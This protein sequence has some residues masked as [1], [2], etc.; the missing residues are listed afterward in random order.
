MA[1]Y[2]KGYEVTMVPKETKG[3][4]YALEIDTPYP[5]KNLSLFVLMMNPSVADSRNMDPTVTTIIKNLGKNYSRII[6][7]NTTPVIETS[8]DNLKNHQSEIN[9]Q[10]MVNAKTV[11]RM[12]KEAKHFHFLVATGEIQKG[13]NDKSYIEL[14]NK[15]DDMTTGD[16][17]YTVRLTKDGYGGHPLYK[18]TSEI[19]NL[20]HIRKADDQWHFVVD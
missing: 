8:S 2:P 17:L 15:I 4:R 3:Y 12:V 6:I 9:Q 11:G 20:T 1:V 10:A 5:S 14:M 7:V 18:K 19:Q 16:G 13:V